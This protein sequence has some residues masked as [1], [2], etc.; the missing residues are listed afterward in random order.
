MEGSNRLKGV[1][2]K[3]CDDFEPNPRLGLD[4]LRLDGRDLDD[5]DD[6]GGLVQGKL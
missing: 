3:Y 5:G 1:S 4:V 6:H 2:D